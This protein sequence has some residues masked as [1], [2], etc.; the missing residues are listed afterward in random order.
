MPTLFRVGSPL[1]VVLALLSALL[2]VTAGFGSRMGW[3]HYRVGFQLLSAAAY[4]GLATAVSSMV[5]ILL[6]LRFRTPLHAFMATGALALS[7]IVVII[8]WH[9]QQ[10]ARTVPAIHDIT[11]DTSNPP[12]FVAILPLRKDA[13]NSV[14]YAGPALATQQ[15]KAYPDIQPLV[16]HLPRTLALNKALKAAEALGWDIVAVDAAEGRIEAT[17]TTF[18]FGF[19]D[20]IA[21]RLTAFDDTTRIDVRSVSRVGKSD[22]GA[23][24]RRIRAFLEKIRSYAE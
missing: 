23:N 24:A 14:E 8:P 3:W 21:V 2:A 5:V 19:K 17:D 1:T 10:T 12:S 13:P 16:L 22:V 18:W 9:M 6:S 15:L 7:L 4:L 11:T 20:D